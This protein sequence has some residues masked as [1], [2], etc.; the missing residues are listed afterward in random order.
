[1]YQ[2]FNILFFTILFYLTLKSNALFDE[3]EACYS[4]AG[5]T[6][7]P[8]GTKHAG[9][10]LQTTKAV[11]EFNRCINIF[12]FSLYHITVL[13]KKTNKNTKIMSIA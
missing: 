5:G 3:D 1:M 7:Y 13:I 6:V 9:H 4:Y 10:Q 11:S 2:S 12:F 8:T